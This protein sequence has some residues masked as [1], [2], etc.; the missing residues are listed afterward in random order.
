MKNT[1]TKSAKPAV[2][3]GAL[4]CYRTK[5]GSYNKATVKDIVDDENGQLA[6][7]TY[8]NKDGQVVEFQKLLKNVWVYTGRK[9]KA[10]AETVDAE[11]AA[12]AETELA[13]GEKVFY[14]TKTGKVGSA[15]V[16]AIEGEMAT[17]KYT[18]F[19]TNGGKPVTK[20]LQRALSELYSTRE[21]CD[22]ALAAEAEVA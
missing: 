22:A 12:P 20:K 18:F 13:V 10:E 5:A 2:T 4:V 15:T 19:N 16:A 9:T 11:A 7:L 3:V 8:T 21:A 17:I 1:T 6:V 14:A